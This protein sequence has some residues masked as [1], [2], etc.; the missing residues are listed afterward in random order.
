L[1]SGKNA[2]GNL[3]GGYGSGR[4]AGYGFLVDK[5]EDFLSI[6][7]SFLR[8]QKALAIGNSG[9]LSWSRRGERFAS[10]SYRVESAGLRLI[11]RARSGDS[12]WRD[13]DDLIPFSATS[14]QFGGRR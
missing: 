14:T 6:D 1:I 9:K 12:D 2:K 10:V 11:Y 4:S 13:I 5:C 8:K 3:M 7:L